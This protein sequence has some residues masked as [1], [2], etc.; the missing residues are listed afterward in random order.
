MTSSLASSRREREEMSDS[1]LFLHLSCMLS[2]VE[3]PVTWIY[4]LS[5]WS[6]KTL[7]PPEVAPSS[8]SQSVSIGREPVRELLGGEFGV[9][10]V[11]RVIVVGGGDGLFGVRLV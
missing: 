1:P 8:A 10:V 11:E 3:Q 2:V 9:F 4:P 5:L 6:D 7:L